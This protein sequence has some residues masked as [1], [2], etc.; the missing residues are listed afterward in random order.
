MFTEDE[1]AA[2]RALYEL[3]CTCGVV[4]TEDFRRWNLAQERV[5]S[6]IEKMAALALHGQ[7]LPP[8]ESEPK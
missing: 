6:V 4:T 2:V 1:V 7:P 8:Q 5:P 3:A